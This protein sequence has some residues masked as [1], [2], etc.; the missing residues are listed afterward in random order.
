MNLF[1]DINDDI[2]QWLSDNPIILGAGALIIG[3][4]LVGLG[5]AAFRSG[6]ATLK[7]GEEVDGW[8]AKMMAYVWLIFGVLASLFGVYKIAS[9]L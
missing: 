7:N 6:K 3:L 4:I 1:A 5:V 8:Q 9:G 2:N